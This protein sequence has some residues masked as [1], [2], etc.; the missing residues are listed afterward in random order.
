MLNEVADA[1]LKEDSRSCQLF[2]VDFELEGARHE[3]FNYAVQ[4]HQGN[5]SGQET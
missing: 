5:S 2:P 1:N 4:K 3:V